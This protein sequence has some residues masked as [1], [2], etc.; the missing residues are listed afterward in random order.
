MRELRLAAG[1][2]RLERLLVKVHLAHGVAQQ[3]DLALGG[4]GEELLSLGHGLG[5]LDGGAVADGPDGAGAALHAQVL[6]A[7]QRAPVLLGPLGQG[8]DDLLAQRVQLDAR[9]P[10]RQPERHLALHARGLVRDDHH[11]LLDLVHLLVEQAVD[12]GALEE[13]RGVL[14]DAP[15]VRRQDLLLQVHDLDAHKRHQARRVHAADV[16]VHHVVQLGGELHPRGPGA[17]HHEGEQLL[18]ARVRHV[19]QRGALE[20]LAHLA[21][22][23]GRVDDLLEEHAVLRH[24]GHA[25]GVGDGAHGGNEVVVR[26]V[27]RVPWERHEVLVVGLVHVLD[28]ERR[29][30]GL[31]RDGLRLGVDGDARRLEVLVP[32]GGDGAAD[33]LHDGALLHGARGGAGQQRR[34]QEVVARGHQHDVVGGVLLE[35]LDEADGA[36]AAAQHHHLLAPGALSG[37]HHLGRT[38]RGGR[39]GVGDGGGGLVAGGAGGGAGRLDRLHPPQG[40]APEHGPLL[41]GRGGGAGVAGQ[42]SD[43]RRR[44]LNLFV[45]RF[46]L[47]FFCENALFSRGDEKA[48]DTCCA[49]CV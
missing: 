48:R 25:E 6:V 13:V 9:A 17:D 29:V 18:D 2:R 31:A 39:G 14:R 1:Q 4:H 12:V 40:A 34:V 49:A 26:D 23:L 35:G 33:G 8:V 21:P 43:A 27:E 15:V 47:S 41:G 38:R 5:A 32:L 19:R 42:G 20:A 44:H 7:R 16:L 46:L 11:A 37:R 30:R 36:P 28:V 22:E 45:A 10:H 3:V 24:T